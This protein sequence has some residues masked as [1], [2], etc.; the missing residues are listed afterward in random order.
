VTPDQGSR[1]FSVGEVDPET[2]AIA[3]SRVAEAVRVSGTE[4]PM[5]ATDAR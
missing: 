5:K 4:R 3:R 2:S 1:V